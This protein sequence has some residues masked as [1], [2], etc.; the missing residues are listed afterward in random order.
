LEYP[1]CLLQGV[2][3]PVGQLQKRFER[4]DSHSHAG[5]KAQRAVAEGQGVEEVRV[6][7]LVGEEDLAVGGDNLVLGADVLEEA[8][9]VAGGLNTAPHNQPTCRTVGTWRI[10]GAYRR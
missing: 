5:Q 8:H 9:L 6:R 10:G 1:A 7:V 4:F 3:G 2:G